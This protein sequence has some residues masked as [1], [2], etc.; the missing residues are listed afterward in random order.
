MQMELHFELVLVL[1]VMIYPYGD[2]R[3]VGTE[4]GPEVANPAAGIYILILANK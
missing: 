4:D 1:I 2:C 3:A